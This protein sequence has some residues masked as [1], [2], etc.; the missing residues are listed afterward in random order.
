MLTAIKLGMPSVAV[1]FARDND[2]L[3]KTVKLKVTVTQPAVVSWQILDEAGNVVRT[4]S[5]VVAQQPATDCLYLGRQADSGAWAPDGWYRS[6]ITATTDAGSYAQERRF[7]AGAFKATPSTNTPSRGGPLTLTIA[8]T[9]R[10]L[11]APVIHVTQ[12]GLAT[13]DAT[14]VSAGRN[15]YKVTINLQAGGDAGTLSLVVAGT[16]KNGGQQDSTFSS[17]CANPSAETVDEFGDALESVLLD[18]AAGRGAR[19]DR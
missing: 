8:S 13:W 3:S 12:P 16:D 1:F 9:E 11:G 6:V 5:T 17:R 14:A 18:L 10:L 2:A 7:Y 4:G 19:P 15:K